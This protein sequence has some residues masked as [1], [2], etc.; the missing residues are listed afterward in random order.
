MVAGFARRPDGAVVVGIDA[1]PR[2]RH[3]TETV[4]ISGQDVRVLSDID[5]LDQGID[6]IALLTAKDGSLWVGTRQNGIYHV[7]TSR[8]D[9]YGSNDGLSGDHINSMIQDVEGNIWIATTDGIDRLR[10][11][12]IVTFSRKE[13]LDVDQ[14]GSVSAGSKGSVWISTLSGLNR[15]TDGNLESI[16][17]RAAGGGKMVLTTFEDSSGKLWISTSSHLLLYSNGKYE[18]IKQPDGS[19]VLHPYGVVQDSQGS[20]WIQPTFNSSGASLFRMTRGIAVPVQLGVAQRIMESH[21]DPNNGLWLRFLGSSDL[22]LYRDGLLSKAIEAPRSSEFMFFL[23][24][25]DGGVWALP[26]HGLLHWS[27]G[28]WKLLDE[29]GGLPCSSM[30]QMQ[31]D[32]KG[33]LW[34]LSRCGLQ[35]IAGAEIRLWAA[36]KIEVV[37][38]QWYG[39]SDGAR[40]MSTYFIPHSTLASDGTLWFGGEAGVQVFNPENLKSNETPPP[41]H[42]E[43]LMADGADYAPGARLRPLTH[44]VEI[45]YTALSL[46]DSRRIQFRYRLIGSDKRWQDATSRRQAF[47]QDLRPGKYRFEVLASNN[48]GVWNLTGDAL[49]FTVPPAFYQTSWFNGMIV[50]LLV[51]SVWLMTKFRAL[52]AAS[53]IEEKMRERLMERDRIARELHDTLLQ[54][55]QSIVFRF[56]TAWNTMPPE[57]RYSVVISDTLARADA[58][59]R[60]GRAKIHDLRGGEPGQELWNELKDFIAWHFPPDAPQCSVKWAGRMRPLNEIVREEV[61]AVAKEALLNALNHSH[62]THIICDLHFEKHSFTLTC[63]DDGVG[64]PADVVVRGRANHY[65]LLGMRERSQRVGGT[66]KITP[67]SPHGTIVQMHIPGALAYTRDR[68]ASGPFARLKQFLFQTQSKSD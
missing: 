65:G 62:G 20:I 37:H 17:V 18:T 51:I 39:P 59:L 35:R 11:P 44:N 21:A 38:P 19:P 9:H 13:G 32:I 30:L 2:G 15:Y 40:I 53:F 5:T 23:A 31:F 33:D 8:T 36:G 64:I 25:P 24:E 63:A 50:I 34:L 41:V 22:Y 1:A 55:F 10:V 29:N 49:T 26:L 16:P 7:T 68:I 27:Q 56:Q 58:V 12:K 60:E 42:I 46:V 28:R 43:R 54:G 66:L 61:V 4:A 45:D 6:V 67:K 47:Y 3:A 52:R 57:Q 14:V 48:D